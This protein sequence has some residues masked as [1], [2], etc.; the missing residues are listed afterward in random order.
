[1]AVNNE[2]GSIASSLKRKLVSFGFCFM[3]EHR[4]QILKTQG[5]QE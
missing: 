1:M 5:R 2:Q 4:P 3:L